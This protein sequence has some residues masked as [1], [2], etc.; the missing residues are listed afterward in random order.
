VVSCALAAFLAGLRWRMPRFERPALRTALAVVTAGSLLAMVVVTETRR[1]PT[2]RTYA[3]AW[4]A[5]LERVDDMKSRGETTMT[6][7]LPANPAAL[8]DIGNDPRGWVTPCVQQYFGIEINRS[9][10][11]E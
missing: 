3:A 11:A 8:G 1:I 7:T 10:S 5:L 4:E 6:A 2:M 9:G